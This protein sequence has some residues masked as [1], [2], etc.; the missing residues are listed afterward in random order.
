MRRACCSTRRVCLS[1]SLS[2]TALAGAMGTRRAE[3]KYLQKSL[4]VGNKINVGFSLKRF[5]L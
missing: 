4:D 2:V 3:L 1:V 5:S